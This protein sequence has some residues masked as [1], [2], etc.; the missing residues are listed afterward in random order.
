MILTIL[1]WIRIAGVSAAFYLGYQAGFE[2]GYDA[3]AQLHVM[4][5][6]T[7]VFIAGIS[8]LEGL[9]FGREAAAAKGFHGDANYQRQSAFALL[10]YTVTALLVYYTDWGVKAELTILFTFLLFFFLSGINHGIDAIRRRNY[11]W[12][13]INRPFITLLLIAGF[14]YPVFIAIQG[15]H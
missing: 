9:F 13:N 11:A 10:S 14:V 12:Q 15:L 3:G 6:L 7:I 5:P 4:V 1:D 2:N 8:A